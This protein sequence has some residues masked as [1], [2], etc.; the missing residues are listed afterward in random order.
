MLDR[1]LVTSAVILASL[2]VAITVLGLIV[3]Q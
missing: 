1:L 3:M 2:T